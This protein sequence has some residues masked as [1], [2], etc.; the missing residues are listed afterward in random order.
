MADPGVTDG[1]D[2]GIVKA[3][4]GVHAMTNIRYITNI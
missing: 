1:M 3:R 2:S 4:R